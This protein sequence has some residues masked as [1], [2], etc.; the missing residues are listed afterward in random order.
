MT[1]RYNNAVALADDL[2]RAS[3][4]HDTDRVGFGG[5]LPGI[6][7]KYL[8]RRKNRKGPL[9]GRLCWGRHGLPDSESEHQQ[10]ARRDTRDLCGRHPSFLTRRVVSGFRVLQRR[11][12]LVCRFNHQ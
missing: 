4:L 3:L 7:F 9:L 12:C 6:A 2:E 1:L 5:H 8:N 11:L 10:A